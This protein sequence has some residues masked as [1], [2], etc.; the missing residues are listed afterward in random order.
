MGK[1]GLDQRGREFRIGFLRHER[2][3]SIVAEMK[4]K[5]PPSR[6]DA[7]RRCVSPPSTALTGCNEKRLFIFQSKLDIIHRPRSSITQTL[8]FF[9]RI[10]PANGLFV[11]ATAATV[12]RASKS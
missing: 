11:L 2:T 8:S 10:R 6:R 9:I 3:K 12:Q 4:R 1:N 5:A 7:H